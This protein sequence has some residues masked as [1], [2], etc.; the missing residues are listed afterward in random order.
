[1][2]TTKATPTARKSTPRKAT[3]RTRKSAPKTAAAEPAAAPPLP[4]KAERA[5]YG[6]SVRQQVPLGAHAELVTSDGGS[7]P[8][9]LLES[10]ST[11]RV[12]ELVPIRYG[13][14]SGPGR[15]DD[16]RSA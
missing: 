4:S 10:Q 9:E 14:Y 1:M 11:M 3:P 16:R 6:K 13:R 5:A 2:T 8:V 7:D 12:P 15:L